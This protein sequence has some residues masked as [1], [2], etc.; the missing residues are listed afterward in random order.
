[1]HWNCEKEKID[2]LDIEKIR[3]MILLSSEKVWGITSLKKGV[4]K[5]YISKLLAD[6]L[7]EIGKNVLRI[8]VGED[9]AEGDCYI[10]KDIDEAI[11]VFDK[12]KQKKQIC[13]NDLKKSGIVVFDNKF[14]QLLDVCKKNYDYIIVDTKAVEETG[15]AKV[16]CK[17]CDENIVIL[18]KDAE[19]GVT[20][21]KGIR[22]LQKLGIK[23]FGAILNEYYT[24][25]PMLRV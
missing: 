23:I 13:I 5:S 6:A 9:I 19:D 10:L 11:E 21:G 2:M 17:M 1:M 22:Q 14:E 18:L 7:N 3:E 4:G 20:S 25:K 24:K 15:Y 16:I 8:S 12:E